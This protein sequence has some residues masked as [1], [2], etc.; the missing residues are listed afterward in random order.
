MD[1]EKIIDEELKVRESVGWLLYRLSMH[2]EGNE[3]MNKSGTIYKIADAFNLYCELNQV[4]SNIKYDIY[5]LEAMINL[6]R[7][8]VNIKHLLG[9]GLLKTFNIVLLNEDEAY[10]K[11]LSKGLYKQL[12][13]LILS[14][15]KNV[16][17]IVEGKE[18]AYKEL[19]ILLDKIIS[20]PINIV[21]PGKNLIEFDKIINDTTINIGESI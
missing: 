10:S 13:E 4:E 20:T 7:Y 17:L 2:K 12:R 14:A 5:L 6:S 3:M 16:T 8:D 15:C 9:K 1:D 11:V 21:I 18:E 19:N